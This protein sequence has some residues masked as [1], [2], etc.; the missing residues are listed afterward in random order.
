MEQP[1]PSGKK[2]RAVSEETRAKLSEKAKRPRRPPSEET[3]R[4]IA[5]A[6]KGRQ[7]N[8]DVVAK[9]EATR[10]ERGNS[11]ASGQKRVLSEETRRKMSESRK[12]KPRSKE[13]KRKIAEALRGRTL[14]PD[15]VAKREATRRARGTSG[16]AG[17]EITDEARQHMREAK[18]GTTRS[19]DAKRKTSESLR[20]HYEDH[21]EL[22]QKMSNERRGKRVGGSEGGWHQSA[23]AKEKIAASKRG[24]KRSPEVRRAIALGRAQVAGGGRPFIWHDYTRRDGTVIRVQGTYELRLCFAM[25]ALRWDWGKV[26]RRLSLVQY[27]WEDGTHYYAPDFVVHR[28]GEGSYIEVKGWMKPQDEVKIA[29]FRA[30][31]RTLHVVQKAE[32]EAI[33]QEAGIA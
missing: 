15:R 1:Q 33:E 12:G 30:T 6:L 24:K 5:K 27:E 26:D 22:R 7:L 16:S 25:D 19:E 17:R 18:L 9:R 20:Q 3:K 31:G 14:D 23:E 28:D 10:R 29:A 21:P 2:K 8:P 13:T 11:G 4:K 32:L